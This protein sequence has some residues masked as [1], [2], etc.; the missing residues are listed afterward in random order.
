MLGLNN[1]GS[2][3]GLNAAGVLLSGTNKLRVSPT[4]GPSREA[5]DASTQ[6]LMAQLDHKIFKLV[7]MEIMNCVSHSTMWLANTPPIR[8]PQK[9]FRILLGDDLSINGS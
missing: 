8:E 5:L 1:D 3:Q 7:G 4:I 2:I 9:D 6:K